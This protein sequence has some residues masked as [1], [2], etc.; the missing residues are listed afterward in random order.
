MYYSPKYYIIALDH[1][2]LDIKYTRDLV[3]ANSKGFQTAYE[4]NLRLLTLSNMR[5][6]THER[7]STR[8]FGPSVLEK[9]GKDKAFRVFLKLLRYNSLH[10]EE[11]R[12]DGIGP[13]FK[14]TA[15]IKK[16]VKATSIVIDSPSLEC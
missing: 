1:T 12:E 15:T 3:N 11:E 6:I 16:S 2:M 14:D 7:C 13:G 10:L 5:K 9:E 8:A 4:I